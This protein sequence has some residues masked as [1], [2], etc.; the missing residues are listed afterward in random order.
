MKVLIV[1]SSRS[2]SQVIE[3]TLRAAGY[4]PCLSPDE[5]RAKL[6]LGSRTDIAAIVIDLMAPR[7]GGAQLLRWIRESA[8]VK[9]P[10]IVVC[11]AARDVNRVAHCRYYVPKPVRKTELLS[12]LG[13]AINELRRRRAISGAAS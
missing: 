1:D 7:T 9:D 12:A 3:A 10:A 4:E 13:S 6:V 8:L 11:S 5:D 2:D